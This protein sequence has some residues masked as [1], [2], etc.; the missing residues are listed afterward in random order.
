LQVYKM[1]VSMGFG[2]LDTAALAKVYELCTAVTL[3]LDDQHS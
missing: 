2:D 3:H 1:G